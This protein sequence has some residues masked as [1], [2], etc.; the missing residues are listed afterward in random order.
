MLLKIN[1]ED[2]RSEMK[3]DIHALKDTVA[4]LLQEKKDLSEESIDK[5]ILSQYTHMQKEIDS[6]SRQLKREQRIIAQN[7]NAYQSIR[8]SLIK[9]LISKKQL[10]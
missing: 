2:Q 10:L 1:N 7:K 9:A 8:E 4:K 3:K 5:G 6:I